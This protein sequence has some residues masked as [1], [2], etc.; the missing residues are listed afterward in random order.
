MSLSEALYSDVRTQYKTAKFRPI[1]VK[2]VRDSSNSGLL[3]PDGEKYTYSNKFT[4]FRCAIYEGIKMYGVNLLEGLTTS[5]SSLTLVSVDKRA[6]DIKRGDRVTFENE[7]YVV[8]DA[9]IVNNI[10]RNSQY[11]KITNNQIKVIT[12]T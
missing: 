10:K 5:G 3:N 2:D 9:N 11:Q 4:Y 1:K 7:E 8:T 12:L 6:M